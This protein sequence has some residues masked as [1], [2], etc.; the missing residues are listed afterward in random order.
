MLRP[1]SFVA[2]ALTASAGVFLSQPM[3][4]QSASPFPEEVMTST[5]Q[6]MSDSLATYISG[7]SCTEVATI[8]K[9]IPTDGSNPAPDPNSIIGSVIL[10]VKNSPN[11][12]STIAT[13]VGPPLISKMLEC[14]MVPVELLMKATMTGNSR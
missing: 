12:Q 1:L 2:V 5:V 3:R 13:R 7:A 10:T 8:V 6:Q 14:N 9:M 4:A 11:L